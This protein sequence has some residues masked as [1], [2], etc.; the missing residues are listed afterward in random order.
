[1]IEKTPSAEKI[2]TL[3]STNS[4]LL[5]A[6]AEGFVWGSAGDAVAKVREE[7]REVEEAYVEKDADHLEEEVGDLLLA[8]VSMSRIAGIAA[9]AALKR[10]DEKFNRRFSYVEQRMKSEHLP[11]DTAH[12]AEMEQFWKDAKKSEK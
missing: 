6:E 1:M 10:A 12:T 3:A 9:D 5:K 4:L 2:D 8:V 7:L 11:L